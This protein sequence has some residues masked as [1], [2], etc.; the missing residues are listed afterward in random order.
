MKIATT[1]IATIAML[2]TAGTATALT[3]DEESLTFELNG[4]IESNCE[5]T[6]DGNVAYDVDMTDF[7]NQGFAAVVFSCNSPYELTI[8]SLNG[9]MKHAESGGT[10]NIEYDVETFGF[11]TGPQSFNS[12]DISATPGVVVSDTDWV[13]ILANIG[14]Q[15]GN[16]DLIFPGFVDSFVAGTYEDELTLTLSAQL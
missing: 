1:A 10:I 9:G 12:S 15:A 11:A 5:L 8:S 7:G 3:A 6:P 4:E 2:A 13:N 16:L 14:A